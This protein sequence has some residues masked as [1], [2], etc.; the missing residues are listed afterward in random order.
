V[1]HDYAAFAAGELPLREMLRYPPFS[2]MVRLVI[3]GP[4]EPVAAEFAKHLAERLQTAVSAGPT[5]ARVLGPAPCPLARLKGEYRFQVQTQA[6]DGEQ[7]RSAVAAA[8]TNRT[9][10][11][12][13]VLQIDVDPVDML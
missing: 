3:R 7:L 10:P 11:D 5:D 2:T 4:I 1:R 13:V 12:D 8:T 6:A 9:P